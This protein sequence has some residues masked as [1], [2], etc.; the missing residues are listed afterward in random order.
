MTETQLARLTSGAYEAEIRG[1][2]NSLSALHLNEHLSTVAH[3]K[4]LK[5]R[6][7]IDYGDET[8]NI[9]KRELDVR[10]RV[11][12]GDAEIVTKSGLFADFARREVCLPIAL[13]Q[14][15]TA[16]GLLAQ[17]GYRKGR[18][19]HRRIAS[20]V[21]GSVEVS[22]HTA[23]LYSEPD[24]PYCDFF[25]IELLENLSDVVSAEQRLRLIVSELGL[26]VFSADNWIAF[27]KDLNLNANGLFD[28]DTC[29]LESLRTLH[30][31]KPYANGT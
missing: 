10:V 12:N 20:Y 31:F 26:K 29:E 24:T 1:P 21:L 7:F 17:L 3:S 14:F 9:G 15:E 2:L 28:F 5:Y 8:D 22:I 27:V 4:S 25:E 19:C 13:E 23:F 11:T 30:P 6:F 16:L 18:A